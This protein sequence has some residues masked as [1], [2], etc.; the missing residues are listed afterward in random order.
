[1]STQLSN[2]INIS[3]DAK[4]LGGALAQATELSFRK[5]N[6]KQH[7]PVTWGGQTYEDAARAY[8]LN[9]SEDPYTNDS[10]MADIFATKLL[11]YPRLLNAIIERGGALWLEQCS[12]DDGDVITL[13]SGTSYKSRYIRSL[14]QGYCY[15]HAIKMGD[16]I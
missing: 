6:I 1:M 9:R 14:I 7:Y 5:G 3:P 13:W 8:Q 15:A 16:D 2:P 10:L 4:G 12:H 11:A